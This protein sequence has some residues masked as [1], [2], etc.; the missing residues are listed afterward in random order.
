[1][2]KKKGEEPGEPDKPSKLPEISEKVE[3]QIGDLVPGSA[4]KQVVA[5]VSK[6]LYEERFS[7]PIPHPQHMAAYEEICPGA[8]D[9]LISMAEASLQSQIEEVA[10]DISDRKQGLW[11]GFA[12]FLALVVAA[13]ACAIYGQVVFAGLLLGAG[14]IGI[15]AR[16]VTRHYGE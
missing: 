4:R 3:R 2:S 14:V 8:A 12:A 13:A 1:M 5:R 15:V 16:F 7:G 9:R 11:M 6:M 10:A